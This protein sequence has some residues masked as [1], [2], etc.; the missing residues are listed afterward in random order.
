MNGVVRRLASEAGD[1]EHVGAVGRV[2]LKARGSERHPLPATF[3]PLPGL[4]S[5][6]RVRG[7]TSSPAGCPPHSLCPSL[8]AAWLCL[9]A[10]E[11]NWI[12]SLILKG[13]CGPQQGC[14][15]RSRRRFVDSRVVLLPLTFLF[16]LCCGGQTKE[17]KRGVNLD[18]H[19]GTEKRTYKKI[20]HTHNGFLFLFFFET[21]RFEITPLS[22]FS[23]HYRN[24]ECQVYESR[25]IG[26][27][28][29]GDG[30]S[31][32]RHSRNQQTKMDWNG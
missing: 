14:W 15:S 24:L 22:S 6:D 28:Q 25:Q 23:E 2:G 4:A 5:V 32:C 16:H 13:I 31:E 3:C 8:A 29:T 10:A 27:G 12:C 20:T 18:T 11:I 19:R 7:P 30:K 26:S 9:A 17:M 21:K 1:S